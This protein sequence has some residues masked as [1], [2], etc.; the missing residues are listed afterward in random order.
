MEGFLEENGFNSI[1]ILH[2]TAVAFEDVAICGTRGWSSQEDEDDVR[3]YDREK[4]RLILSLEEARK[5]K[6]SR[7]IVGMHYP[8]IGSDNDDRSF[9]EIMKNYGVSD[10]VYGHLHSF[11]HKNAIIGDCDG[12]NLMLVSGDYTNFAPV[13]VK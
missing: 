12:I 11:A 8:P 2:N 13:L 1:K 4:R 5:L 6:T 7:I 9:I 3:I 10:C